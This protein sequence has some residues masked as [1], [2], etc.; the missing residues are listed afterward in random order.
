MVM[1]AAGISTL[2]VQ[3]LFQEM[4]DRRTSARVQ[5]VYITAFQILGEAVQDLLQTPAPA[6]LSK[7]QRSKGKQCLVKVTEP[8][9]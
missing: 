1:H 2:L 6:A 7:Q 3:K 4:Q 8:L 9:H 5:S